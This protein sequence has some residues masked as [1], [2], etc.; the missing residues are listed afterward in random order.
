MAGMA[1]GVRSRQLARESKQ[2]GGGGN[3]E[4]FFSD[5]DGG[6]AESGGAW[7]GDGAENEDPEKNDGRWSFG[8]QSLQTWWETPQVPPVEG[9]GFRG[10]FKADVGQFLESDP[11]EGLVGQEYTSSPL[12]GRGSDLS[13]GD[14]NG[15][16]L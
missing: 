11:T 6:T 10:D 12:V 8:L 16:L 14:N 3:G 4:Y 7:G 5:P 15:S 13:F 1:Y 9:R 2:G